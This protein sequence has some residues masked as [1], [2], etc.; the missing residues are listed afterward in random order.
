MPGLKTRHSLRQVGDVG[1]LGL[2]E[3]E[4]ERDGLG[5]RVRESGVVRVGEQERSPVIGNPI[6]GRVRVLQSLDK[7]VPKA[8][9][10]LREVSCLVARLLRHLRIPDQELRED[11]AEVFGV[12]LGDRLA[13][14]AGDVARETERAA[15]PFTI[16][17]ETPFVAV[18][19]DQVG[20]DLEPFPLL[21]VAILVPGRIGPA[22]GSLQFHVTAERP[23]HQHAEVRDPQ[24]V[25]Q[26]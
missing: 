13:A 10:E 1:P 23:A 20:L 25:G 21:C 6:E 16:L 18:R 12:L 17:I 15:D 9:A 11:R 14:V 2:G 24:A 8:A 4:R 5:V 26:G 3:Q 7:V 19:V 22:P